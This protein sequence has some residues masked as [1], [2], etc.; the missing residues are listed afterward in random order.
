MS[1]NEMESKARELRQLQSLI[2]EATAEAEALKDAI[3]AAKCQP[4]FLCPEK[5][6]ARS[7]GAVHQ[8]ADDAPLLRGV[9]QKE[10]LQR[11]MLQRPP[12][13]EI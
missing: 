10:P 2:E 6:P 1:I 13:W 4:V 8:A 3:K 11:V 7:G 12:L 5:E 9:N